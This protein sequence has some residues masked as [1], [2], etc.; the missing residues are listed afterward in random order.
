M[1]ISLGIFFNSKVI[2]MLSIQS[3]NLSEKCHMK[4]VSEGRVKSRIPILLQPTCICIFFRVGKQKKIQKSMFIL[5][6]DFSH[7][8]SVLN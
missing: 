8:Y 6:R 2:H 1:A 3:D 4:Q 7:I 5:K